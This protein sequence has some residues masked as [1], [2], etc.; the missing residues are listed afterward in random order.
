MRSAAQTPLTRSAYGPFTPATL[1]ILRGVQTQQRTLVRQSQ[2]QA[3]AAAAYF[4]ACG[5]GVPAHETPAEQ[6]HA[7]AFDL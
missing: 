1:Q 5:A 7:W 6:A 3:A 2:A 4:D